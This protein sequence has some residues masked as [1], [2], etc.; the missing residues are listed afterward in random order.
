MS[1]NGD[2][3]EVIRV[4]PEIKKIRDADLLIGASLLIIFGWTAYESFR[5]SAERIAAGTATIYTAPGLVPFII[6]LIIIF[7]V[8]SVIRRAIS[9]GADLT[10]LSPRGLKASYSVPG[11]F[12][13]MIVMAFLSAYVFLLAPFVPFALSTFIFTAGFMLLYKAAKPVWIFVISFS[14]S[15]VVVNFFSIVVGVRFPV[16]Y[17]YF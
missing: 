17:W 6:S 2:S 9:D 13:A 11:A 7:C 14:F 15:L 10:F 3:G 12:S 16:R 4:S 5:M 8:I 1:A